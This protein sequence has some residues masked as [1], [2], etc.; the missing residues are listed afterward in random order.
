M[1]DGRVL[2]ASQ[3]EYKPF[4]K[5]P[6][7]EADCHCPRVCSF[8][9]TWLSWPQCPQAVSKLMKGFRV[10]ASVLN[11][12]FN[13]EN[14]EFPLHCAVSIITRSKFGRFLHFSSK[15]CV[16]YV[17]CFCYSDNQ[18]DFGKRTVNGPH[19]HLQGRVTRRRGCVF[20]SVRS[21]HAGQRARS[22]GGREG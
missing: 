19:F 6:K 13:L 15:E 16:L 4:G 18:R 17:F 2:G 20:F 12:T 5:P 11:V 14:L 3:V 10:C 7:R 21:L 9:G 22:G 8:Q 1:L